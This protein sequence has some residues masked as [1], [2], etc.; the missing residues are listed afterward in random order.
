[1]ELTSEIKSMQ[2][3]G[4]YVYPNS[5]TFSG[6]HSFFIAKKGMDKHLFVTGDNGITGLIGEKLHID[7]YCFFR[8][9]LNHINA[10]WIRRE[11]DF[12]NPVALGKRGKSLGLGDRLGLA[13]PGH[14]RAVKKQGFQVILAQQSMR[15]LTLMDRNYSAVLDDVTWAVFQE[16]WRLGYGADGDHLKESDEVQAALNKGFTMITVD[17]SNYIDNGIS[18]L[19]SQE[20]FDRFSVLPSEIKDYFCEKYLGKSF[21]VPDDLTNLSIDYNTLELAVIVL[22][23][24]Q[25][26]QFIT[27]LYEKTIKSYDRAVDLEVSL[28]ETLT[29]T[30]LKAHFLIAREMV[31]R[32]IPITGIA[33]RFCGEFQKGIEYKG[34]IEEFAEELRE[35]TAI[36]DYFGYKISVHSGS[37]KFSILN[38][39]GRKSKGN[40]HLKTSG[41][42]YLEAIRL[43]ALREPAFYTQIHSFALANL[44][45][46]RQYYHIDGNPVN[47]K[48]INLINPNDYSAYL[49]QPDMRQILHI[50]YGNIFRATDDQGKDLFRTKIF[51]LL[52]QHEEEHLDLIARHIG[53]HISLLTGSDL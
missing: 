1:M 24:Y 26:L 20:V 50:N 52:R 3:H 23:Y 48:P 7:A 39:I 11:F 49:D 5:I 29:A 34:D 8:C 27:E 30:S 13:T 51:N 42:S 45:Q 40:F 21:Q 33:P 17:C 12:T 18:G 37:D 6:K 25:L 44:E 43:I 2:S 47:V 28:D 9:P 35:H 53:K 32:G 14:I 41:T 38:I 16:G 31:D 15:E 22:T 19:G 36:A 10:C 46:A 4:W